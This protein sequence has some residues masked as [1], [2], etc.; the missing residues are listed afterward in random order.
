M[1]PRIM[2]SDFSAARLAS[3]MRANLVGFERFDLQ[4]LFGQEADGVAVVLD[5]AARAV[6]ARH[7]HAAD[8]VVHALRRRFADAVRPV[9]LEGVAGLAVG[10]RTEL[11]HAP[12][13]H[14][15]LG[16]VGGALDVVRG[17]AR[18]VVH[19]ELFG[20]APAHQ[21]RDLRLEEALRV[22]VAIGL[23]QL[24]R[25]AHRAAAR[26]D[27]DLV[28]RVGVGQERRD[29]GV[30]GLVIGAVDAIQVAQHDRA[31]LDAHQHLV[32]RRVQVGVGDRGSPGAPGEQRRLVDQV[33]EVGAR[34]P[35]RARAR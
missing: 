35:R 34:E 19:E 22:G 6:V 9:G 1:R 30:A 13:A 26:D 7:D 14:H 5:D 12:L 29:D 17:A 31:P 2:C 15:V 23:R 11:R 33:G 28:Q 27:R 4:Q 10:E 25:H 3:R 32:A 8:L 20:D 24:H 21:H 18:H 16:D